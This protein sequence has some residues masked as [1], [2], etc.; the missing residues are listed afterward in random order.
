MTDI[1]LYVEGGGRTVASR[2]LLRAGVDQ[3]LGK[4]RAAAQQRGLQLRVICCGGR[5]EARSEFVAARARG[6][7]R[8]LLLVDSELPVASDPRTHLVTHDRWADL[9]S[10]PLETI[11]LMV[12][13]ME[14]WIV[15]DFDA[16]R[17][18]YGECLRVE[19]L[20]ADENIEGVSKTRIFAALDRATVDTPLGEYHK[21][22]DASALLTRVDPE[23]VKARCPNCKRL[24]DT[25]S[26]MIEAT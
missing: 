1:E 23:K 25:L 12:Q 18:H 21:L 3:F 2:G 11:Q 19:E 4:L 22:H 20:P 6:G 8:A 13:V 24:F 9:A 10:A 16:L 5:G 14:T 7:C 26:L 15:A 17:E